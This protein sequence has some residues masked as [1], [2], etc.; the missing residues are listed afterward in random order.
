MKNV[1]KTLVLAGF[2]T[3]VATAAM[4]ATTTLNSLPQKGTVNVEG[5]VE[6]L[7]GK[8]QFTLNDETGK[9][10]VQATKA[11]YEKLR[12]GER[13]AVTGTVKHTKAGAEINASSVTNT[14]APAAGTSTPAETQTR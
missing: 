13:V 2:A 1:L 9:A 7:D 3:V 14:P 5:V 8:N 11:E 6:K 4:A 12:V 10:T